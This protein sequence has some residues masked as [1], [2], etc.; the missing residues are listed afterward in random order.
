VSKAACKTILN[1]RIS[2]AILNNL[3][4]SVE[5]ESYQEGYVDGPNTGEIIDLLNSIENA[6]FHALRLFLE[7]VGFE[8]P[9]P[10]S[11]QGNEGAKPSPR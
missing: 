4:D 10:L 3:A 11:L 5:R 6:A 9:W 8:G 7:D 2:A 1:G